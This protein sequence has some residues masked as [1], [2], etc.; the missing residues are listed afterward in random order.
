MT[1]T[2]TPMSPLATSTARPHTAAALLF[3]TEEQAVAGLAKVV[4]NSGVI[5]TLRGS[6][7]GLSMAAKGAVASRIGA[8]ASEL[9]GLDLADVLAAAWRKHT[10][11]RSAAHR[12][13][14]DP[15]SIELVD[16][17]THRITSSH[18]PAVDLLVDERKVATVDFL[19][20]L[21]FV[22]RGMVA[23]VKDGRLTALQSGACRASAVLACE[24]IDLVRRER[25]LDLSR[26]LDLDAGV[27]LLPAGGGRR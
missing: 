27:V 10:A 13:L 1:P 11:L 6:L 20:E 24:G 3:G 16:L 7:S 12:T 17:A 14:A 22:I 23:G 21:S 26:T 4:S 9:A 18:H 25:E 19:L 5:D 15:G 2:T 8:I